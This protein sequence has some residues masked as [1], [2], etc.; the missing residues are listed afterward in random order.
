MRRIV[1]LKRLG[2]SQRKLENSGDGQQPVHFTTLLVVLSSIGIKPFFFEVIE[3][4][5]TISL[6]LLSVRAAIA[7]F[8]Y[9]FVSLQ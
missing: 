3:S 8:R 5:S 4:S 2:W 1:G 9:C 7:H 6:T